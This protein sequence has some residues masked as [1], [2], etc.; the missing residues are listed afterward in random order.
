MA[1]FHEDWDMTKARISHLACPAVFTLCAAILVSS[2][3]VGP[4][5]S[6]AKAF[7]GGDLAS[8]SEQKVL[9]YIKKRFVWSDE[10]LLKRGLRI[11]AIQRPHQNRVQAATATRKIERLYC[12]GTARMNDG[13]KRTIW[14][15]IEKG[16]GFASIGNAVEFCVSGLDPWHVYGAWC[17]SVR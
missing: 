15:M 5:V 2:L 14:Y 9:D 3:L 12:H 16:M 17:R 13:R 4:A 7:S 10:K 11:E 8:C 1:I 6:P